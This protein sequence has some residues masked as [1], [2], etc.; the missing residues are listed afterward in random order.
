[1]NFFLK[2]QQSFVKKYCVL[3]L[4]SLITKFKSKYFGKKILREIWHT[5]YNII[6]IIIYFAPH[7]YFFIYLFKI[8]CA[9]RQM[10][11]IIS[12]LK[13]FFFQRVEY[14]LKDKHISRKNTQSAAHI[15]RHSF[16]DK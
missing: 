13:Q 14:Y 15:M 1:M 16:S 11:I 4:W 6:V 12:I 5:N 3:I 8:K 10:K 7:G 9:K 2:Q